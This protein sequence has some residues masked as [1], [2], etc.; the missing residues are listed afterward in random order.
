M[1]N[2][3]KKKYIVKKNFTFIIL[4]SKS[5]NNSLEDRTIIKERIYK[6][7]DGIAKLYIFKRFLENSAK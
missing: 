7:C 1:K 4:R 5:G 2:F 6:H 3:I